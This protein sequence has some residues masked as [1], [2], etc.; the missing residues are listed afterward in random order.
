M[1]NI[2]WHRLGN[3]NLKQF[4]AFNHTAF[5]ASIR[6]LGG[7]FGYAERVLTRAQKSDKR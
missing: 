7:V 3:S 6:C 2:D 1:P 4:C 5:R